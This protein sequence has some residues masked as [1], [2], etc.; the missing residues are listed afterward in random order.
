[1]VGKH[2]L[3]LYDEPDALWTTKERVDMLSGIWASEK[4]GWWWTDV[5]DCEGCGTKGKKEKIYEL[6]RNEKDGKRLWRVG[7]AEVSMDE[8]GVGD[9]FLRGSV[10]L[11]T[12]RVDVAT[13][14]VGLFVLMRWKVLWERSRAS[15]GKEIEQGEGEDKDSR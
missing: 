6:I 10:S 3:A 8:D 5:S 1:M 13:A 15:K 14:L 9:G 7:R 4:K 12:D 11:E 2:S